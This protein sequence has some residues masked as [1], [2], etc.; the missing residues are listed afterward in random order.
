MRIPNGCKQVSPTKLIRVKTPLDFVIF[1]NGKSAFFDAKSFDSDRIHH[2]WLTPHQIQMLNAISIN[3]VRAGL[4]IWFRKINRVVFLDAQL[5]NA[6]EPNQSAMWDCG[7]VLGSFEEFRLSDI[8]D[9]SFETEP[10]PMTLR[11]S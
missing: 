5:L 9:L 11:L 10:K 2:S 3:G 1:K 8:L 4:L 7:L 6:L